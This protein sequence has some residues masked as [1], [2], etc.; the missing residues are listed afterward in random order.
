MSDPI[1]TV[2]MI[3]AF[4]DIISDG[5]P[6]KSIEQRARFYKTIEGIEFPSDWDD[7]PLDEK[8]R[9]LEKLDRI[10]LS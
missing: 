6:E 1:K 10:G 5:D 9:R 7:L 2:S 8:R 4:F 3:S